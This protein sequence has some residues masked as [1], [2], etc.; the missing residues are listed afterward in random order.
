MSSIINELRIKGRLDQSE[1]VRNVLDPGNFIR[2]N[3]G[4]I[5]ASLLRAAT[6]EEL[7]YDL[8]EEMGSQMKR[9]LGDMIIHYGDSHSEGLNEFFYAIAIKKMRSQ[10]KYY[11]GMHRLI[12]ESKSL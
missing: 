3:D 10:G 5:Q 4:I 9:V 11:Q 2:Y 12:R 1:Y 6:N 7:R 8:T